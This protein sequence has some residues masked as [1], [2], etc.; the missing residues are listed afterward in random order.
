MQNALQYI[1]TMEQRLKSYCDI[2]C[3]KDLPFV[4]DYA[5]VARFFKKEG[6]TFLSETSVIDYY[7]TYEYILFST[8][9][10]SEEVFQDMAQLQ[11]QVKS[12]VSPSRHHK[13]TSLVRVYIIEE[14]MIDK[15]EALKKAVKKFFF[16]QSL[17]WGFFGYIKAQCVLVNLTTSNVTCNRNFIKSAPAFIPQ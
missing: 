1:K 7:E 3:D 15:L 2:L 14:Y 4:K 6:Q 10:N 13:S 12:L 11:R 17:C 16:Q 9:S 5:L 8:N